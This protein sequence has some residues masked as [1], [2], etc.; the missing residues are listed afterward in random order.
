MEQKIERQAEQTPEKK[1]GRTVLSVTLALVVVV[2]LFL[3]I[4]KP[5]ERIANP[6]N[7]DYFDL[8]AMSANMVYAQVNDM[9]NIRPEAYIGKTVKARGQYSVRHDGSADKDY[10]SVVIKDAAACCASGLEF[11]YEGDL[12]PAETT[13]QI[14][15]TFDRYEER[16][17]VYYH[18][19]AASLVAV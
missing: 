10:R 5:W 15:G 3:V 1:T 19:I 11:V 9:I 13:V 4:T 6:K 8:T 12:P 18:I 2:G 14:E 7:T 16:G 17:R